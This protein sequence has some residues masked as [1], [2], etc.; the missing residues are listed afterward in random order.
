MEPAGWGR[1]EDHICTGKDRVWQRN[2]GLLGTR[3]GGGDRREENDKQSPNANVTGIYDI[4]MHCTL[5]QAVE[6]PLCFS[7]EEGNNLLS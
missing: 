4:I 1:R 6:V 5:W 2:N 7:P 3:W